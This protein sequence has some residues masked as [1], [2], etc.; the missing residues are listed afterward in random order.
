MACVVLCCVVLCCVV[1]CCV[2]FKDDSTN[3]AMHSSELTMQI[4]RL[5]S[6]QGDVNEKSVQQMNLGHSDLMSMIHMPG[7]RQKVLS[8]FFFFFL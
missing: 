8:G 3:A 6:F 2:V 4:L 7:T 1:L 5:I